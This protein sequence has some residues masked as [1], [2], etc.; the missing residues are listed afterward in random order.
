MQVTGRVNGDTLY[1]FLS[2][3][4]D[5]YNASADESDKITYTDYIGLML[6]SVTTIINAISY[7]L[8]AFVSIS[9]IVSSIMIG[10]I[11]YISVLERTKEIG[12]RKVHGA[13]ADRIV[14]QFC[15]EYLIWVGISFLIACPIGYVLMR[16]WLSSFAYQTDI[17]WWLFLSAGLLMGLVT[18]L[19]VIGLTRHK[20]SQNPVES[21]R[22]E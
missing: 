9:L 7:I 16:T 8:I 22:Y 17:S 3:E 18:L 15:R 12:I 11:T 13:H 19:T 1:I 21:L 20:A 4:L 2:G 10:I 14:R 6:S 5:E